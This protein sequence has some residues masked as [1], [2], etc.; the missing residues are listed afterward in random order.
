MTRYLT[1]QKIVELGSFTKA[2]DQLGYTQSSVS[3]MIASLEKEL[4]IKLLTRSHNGISLT[5]EGKEIYPFI[6]RM[7][8]QYRAMHE[9]V[10]EIK[11]L[12]T[13]IIRIGIISS[14][15][16]QWMPNLVKGFQDI[17]PNVQF[18]FHQG[19]YSS[20]QEWIKTGS[21]DFGF[22]TPPAVT[23]LMTKSLIKG[24]M[25]LILPENHPL[26][27]KQSVTLKEIADE[28]FILLE[29]G[30]YNEAILA[31]E[32]EGLKPNI[33]FT[34]HDD[35][36]IMKMVQNGMGISILSELMVRDP[37]YKISAVSLEPPVYRDL[38]I[39]YKDKASLP[40]ASKKFISFLFDNLSDL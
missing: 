37:N 2:A 28:P 32:A 23:G 30:N 24:E 40:I 20:I 22:V 15:S 11:G 13:G 19:D 14:I 25:L 1:L 29:E 33:K 5:I 4:E 35:F 31:F 27:I 3:Q 8:N 17:Y 10:N 38:S 9:K 36:T 12:D 34:I 6:E 39:A 18:V 26:S 21:V 7:I 16:Y